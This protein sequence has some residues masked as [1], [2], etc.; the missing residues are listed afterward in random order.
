[1]DPNVKLM[2][3]TGNSVSQLHY[4]QVIGSRMYAMKSTRPDI[5]FAGGKL[6]RYT[7]NP[8]SSHWASIMRV[9]KYLKKTMDFKLFYSGF[10]LVL[11]GYTDASWISNM[12]DHSSISGFVF[13]LGGGAIS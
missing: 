7:S 12:E 2:P 5:A 6:S 9:L 3:N 4:S 10:P 11:E 8:R 13:L 1:M